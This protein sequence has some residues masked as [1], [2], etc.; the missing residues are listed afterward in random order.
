MV[1][2]DF[3]SIYL[4]LFYNTYEEYYNLFSIYG[5]VLASIKFVSDLYL[6]YL[7]PTLLFYFLRFRTGKASLPM[8]TYNYFILYFVF[9]LYFLVVLHAFVSLID[10]AMKLVIHDFWTSNEYNLYEKPFY[11]L[12][13]PIK[14]FLIAI[15]LS[16][17]YYH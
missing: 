17:L 14:D 3:Q 9:F 10:S 4:E 11:T 16:M 7:F 15:S 5:M 13:F 12:V 1:L 6:L 8:T 2:F